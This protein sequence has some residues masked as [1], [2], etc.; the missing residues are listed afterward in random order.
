LTILF[1]F[2]ELIKVTDF[3]FTKKVSEKRT[4]TMCGTP[5]YLAP[6]IILVKVIYIFFFKWF[7]LH[8]NEMADV[9]LRV[10]TKLS[11]GGLLAF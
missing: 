3:G 1:S 5:E 9:N 4:W 7:N 6:E 8:N 11:I 10:T 2:L